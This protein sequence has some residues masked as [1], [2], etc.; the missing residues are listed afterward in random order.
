MRYSTAEA[1]ALASLSIR[2]VQDYYQRGRSTLVRGKDFY[3]QRMKLPDGRFLSRGFFTERGIERLVNRNYKV[4]GHAHPGRSV[5][6]GRFVNRVVAD[7]LEDANTHANRVSPLPST[8]SGI[9]P[10]IP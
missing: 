1:A 10:K 2:T 6:D 7:E 3:I 5:K 8:L 4:F 9:T